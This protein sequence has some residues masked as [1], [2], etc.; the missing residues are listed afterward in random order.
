MVSA[1]WL[2]LSLELSEEPGR[3]VDDK[4]AKARILRLLCSCYINTKDYV[5]ARTCAETANSLCSTHAG[6][7]L[8]TK[9]DLLTK[10]EEAPKSVRNLLTHDDIPFDLIICTL[11]V[12]VMNSWG[13]EL[14]PLFDEII[15][16]FENDSEKYEILCFLKIEL[17]LSHLCDLPGALG[18]LERLLSDHHSGLHTL[19]TAAQ[20]QVSSF[21]WNTATN[22]YA[23]QEFHNAITWYKLSAPL[24][25]Q[26]ENKAQCLRVIS[27]CFLLLGEADQALE[28]ALNARDIEPDST[29]VHFLL[30][31]IF[32]E[33][34]DISEAFE[35]L[36]R[37]SQ[38]EESFD[39][40]EA[41]VVC[42]MQKNKHQIS[43]QALECLI[44]V[45][46]SNLDKSKKGLLS[47]SVRTLFQLL[48]ESQC[49]DGAKK[50]LSLVQ[51]LASLL[52]TE[53]ADHIAKYKDLVFN[54]NMDEMQWLTLVTWNMGV[55]SITE[56]D[57]SSITILFNATL[58]FSSYLPSSHSL[59]DMRMNCLAFVSLG[60]MNGPK[61]TTQVLESVLKNLKK[62][63]ELRAILRADPQGVKLDVQTDLMILS[64]EFEAYLHLCPPNI[65]Q[66]LAQIDALSLKPQ[67]KA[68]LLAQ[69]A[70]TGSCFSINR[71][72][73]IQLL[74][75]SRALFISE[76]NFTAASEITRK[77]I[78]V[79]PRTDSLSYYDSTLSLLRL[80]NSEAYPSDELLWLFITAYNCGIY[81]KYL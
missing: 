80:I 20:Q 35:T 39:Y 56:K 69:F 11:K 55:N 45:T 15:A 3:K 64:I 9:I 22:F 63:K 29:L 27:R 41:S 1:K 32:L 37:M 26:Q 6:S 60:Q 43:K 79:C 23:T 28:W 25:S 5:K 49:S 14:L 62:C 12:G 68:E 36:H 75:E 67:K 54:N 42:A 40:L 21:I 13:A 59:L 31:S 48:S 34:D 7:Y 81:C 58:V 51:T 71:K 2:E 50:K 57:F 65:S 10:S 33:K 17:L 44:N 61:K 30:Y 66:V 76:S 53:D 72:L 16:R 52:Q 70:H 38:S 18:F 47:K 19:S 46:L 73:A 78:T 24:F 8:V 74:E 4:V 77:L